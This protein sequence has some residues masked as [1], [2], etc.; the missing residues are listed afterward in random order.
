M[1]NYEDD[2]QPLDETER[3]FLEREEE[4]FAKQSASKAGAGESEKAETEP[5]TQ[6][7]LAENCADLIESESVLDIYEEELRTS[8]KFAGSATVVM[9]VILA[10]VS[11]L[12][13]QPVSILVRGES[14]AGKSYAIKCA[15]DFMAQGSTY[16][17]TAMSDKALAYGNETLAHRAIVLFEDDALTSGTIAYMMRS[18]LSEGKIVYEFVDFEQGRGTTTIER[19]GPTNLVTTT[20]GKIDYELNTRMLSLNVDTSPDATRSVLESAAAQAE[21]GS[22]RSDL[23]DFR[24]FDLWLAAGPDE[25]VIPYAVKIAQ[26]CDT[27]AVRMRRDLVAVFGLVKAHAL[28]HQAHRE[29]NGD[30][31]VIATP[32]DYAVIYELVADSIALAA[33]ASVPPGV[34]RLVETLKAMGGDSIGIPIS[35][36]ADRAGLNR[37]TISRNVAAAETL[38]LVDNTQ[39]NGK[40]KM[41]IVGDPLPEDRSVLPSPEA[42]DI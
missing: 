7:D 13:A 16:V 1:N 22:G 2:G 21:G 4:Y 5:L 41:L 11:R 28:M 40:K 23:S 34:R 10:L 9:V 35:A 14:S 32:Q 18:L 30:G 42:L 8:G 38:G 6:A 20:P 3:E 37:S 19:D 15:M 36:I 24:E 17:L 33:G 25:A 29:R 26:A 27:A 12:L 31:A 39:Q